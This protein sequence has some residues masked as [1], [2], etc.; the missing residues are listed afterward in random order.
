[1][2][3]GARASK[4]CRVS[5]LNHKTMEEVLSSMFRIKRNEQNKICI[6]YTRQTHGIHGIIWRMNRYKLKKEEKIKKKEK[7]KI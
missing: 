1:M 6:Q 5:S 3:L 4:I 2:H 7:I